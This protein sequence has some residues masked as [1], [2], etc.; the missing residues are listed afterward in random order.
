MASVRPLPDDHAAVEPHDQI[1]FGAPEV[2]SRLE[3]DGPKN[4]MVNSFPSSSRFSGE[5]R[6]SQRQQ[7]S[8]DFRDGHGTTIIIG[9]VLDELRIASGQ[10]TDNPDEPTQV[11]NRLLHNFL[12]PENLSLGLNK[13]TNRNLSARIYVGACPYARQI[14]YKLFIANLPC[15][16]FKLNS[17]ESFRQL[18]KSR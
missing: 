18:Q 17:R 1:R 16:E 4:L 5:P 14:N 12:L 11:T 9:V 13:Q 6:I 10:A 15:M 3:R 2:V 7:G 8:F